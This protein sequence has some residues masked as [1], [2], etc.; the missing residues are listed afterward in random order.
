[1]ARVVGEEIPTD[2]LVSRVSLGIVSGI[3]PIVGHVAS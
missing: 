3:L 2:R 1:L